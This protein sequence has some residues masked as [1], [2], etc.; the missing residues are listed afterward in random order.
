MDEASRMF[1]IMVV[2]DDQ[3]TLAILTHHLQREGFVA[4]EA[5]SGAQCLKLVHE[6]EVDVILLDL[7]MPGMDGFE[8]VRALR[9]DLETA[10]IPIIMLT[11]R[12]DLD[13]R[14]RACAWE[15]ATS[16]PSRYSGANLPAASVHSSKWSRRRAMRPPRWIGWKWCARIACSRLSAR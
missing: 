10:E 15:S 2:D 1:Q 12:D 4:I 6:N 13:A 16:W 14:L 8:V 11:A 9:D 7:M 3:D 5:S